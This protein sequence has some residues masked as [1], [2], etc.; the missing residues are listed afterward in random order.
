MEQIEVTVVKIGKGV[1]VTYGRK[2]SQGL[3]LAHFPATY[4]VELIRGW[5]IS[6]GAQ[7]SPSDFELMQY[8]IDIAAPWDVAQQIYHDPWHV[9]LS[10]QQWRA[11][12][13]GE[14]VVEALEEYP[15]RKRPERTEQPDPVERSST[16]D[17]H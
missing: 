13:Q 14:I 8:M 5:S 3:T 15:A 4:C 6:F 11:G 17:I 2:G 16:P 9:Y 10:A 12:D 1:V 7:T